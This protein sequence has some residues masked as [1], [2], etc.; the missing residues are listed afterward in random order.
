MG[1]AESMALLGMPPPLSTAMPSQPMHMP[2]TY[3]QQ[4]SAPLQQL[5][6][7]VP[8]TLGPGPMEGVPVQPLIPACLLWCVLICQA[9]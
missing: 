4:V 8:L 1:N 5:P 3:G 9:L 6:L 2:A 7:G